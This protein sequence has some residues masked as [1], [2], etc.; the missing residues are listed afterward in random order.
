MRFVQE[1]LKR[2]FQLLDLPPAIA[3]APEAVELAQLRGEITFSDVH[4]GYGEGPPVLNGFD[5]R[6]AAGERVAIVGAS[7]SGKS[8]V[9]MLVSRFRD[10]DSG[11]VLVDGHDLRTVTVKSL[12]RQVGVAF[13]ES[14]LFL[15]LIHI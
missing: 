1:R 3:D 2:I 13:E 14:F 12:R 15:S 4:F 11:T 5:L 10:P 6:I 9:A 7:G 8:T